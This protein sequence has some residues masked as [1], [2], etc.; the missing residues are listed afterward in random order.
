MQRL[1]S[2]IALRDR[3]LQWC[4]NNAARLAYDDNGQ[5]CVMNADYKDVLEVPA[6]FA[7]IIGGKADSEVT[8]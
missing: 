5:R 3:A 4:L 2:E 7:A 6:E 1:R 8:K